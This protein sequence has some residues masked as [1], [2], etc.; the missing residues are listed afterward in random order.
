MITWQFITRWQQLNEI[1]VI[2]VV[3]CSHKLKIPWY[4]LNKTHS[5]NTKTHKT[6]AHRRK[7]HRTKALKIKALKTKTHRTKTHR[8]KARRTKAHRTKAHRTKAHRTK[9]LKRKAHLVF[10]YELFSIFLP[11]I[12]GYPLYELLLADYEICINQKM[13]VDIDALLLTH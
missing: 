11:I 1:I 7:T 12:I 4:I 6:K 3:V 5:H 13:T 8:T 9:A 10:C 2:F